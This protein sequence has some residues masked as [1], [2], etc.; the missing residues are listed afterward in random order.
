M[1][2]PVDEAAVRPAGVVSAGG[3]LMS[4][5]RADRAASDVADAVREHDFV[6][7]LDP[8]LP[9][10]VLVERTGLP[11]PELVAAVIR[12]PLRVVHGKVTGEQA[13]VL[14]P[15]VEAALTALGE[16]LEGTP[17]AAPTAGRLADLGLDPRTV[18][19]AAKAGRLL[20]LAPAIVLLPGADR[21]AVTWLA[22]LPQPF[23]A[24]Q[25]RERLGTSRRVVLPLLDHLDR[26]GRT[27]RLQ[28]DRRVVSEAR[29]GA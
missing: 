10:T 1:G 4:S 24:S 27:R 20:R 28:D 2:V 7:P 21:T 15:A 17:F 14:P 18:A 5:A 9:L 16:D 29:T 6:T 8:G 12:A 19:A 25:A 3:W 23:T 22:E 11:A 26:S 13:A